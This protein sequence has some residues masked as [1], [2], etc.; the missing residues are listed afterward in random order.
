MSH[1]EYSRN[2]DQ[3]H[4]LLNQSAR[5]NALSQ[6]MWLE[7]KALLAQADSDDEIRVLTIQGANGVFSAGADISEFK[8]I[9][10][11][12]EAALQAN[13][14]IACTLQAMD[15]FPKLTI[16]VIQGPCMGGGCALAMACDLQLADTSAIFGINPAALGMAY[17][18]RDCQRLVAR[19]GIQRSKQMLMGARRI[20][21]ET[22]HAWGLISQVVTPE[23]LDTAVSTQIRGIREL[24]SDA[25]RRVKAILGAIDYGAS[26]QNDP[27]QQIFNDSFCS[28]DCTEGVDAFLSKRKPRFE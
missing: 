10:A 4:I 20:S 1:V 6:G 14:V 26:E 25:L 7:I 13:D 17:S 11:T 5:K 12:S 21:A 16:A 2:G 19:I 9:Y 23:A 15:Q 18:F 28:A 22:A 24:S 27:L 8:T 3:A